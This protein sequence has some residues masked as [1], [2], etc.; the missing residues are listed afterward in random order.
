VGG[1]WLSV[2]V[3]FVGG[4]GGFLFGCGR[5]GV[6]GCWVWFLVLLF[7]WFVGVGVF[8]FGVVGFRG[9][10]GGGAPQR[11]V[12]NLK[13]SP[14]TRATTPL[15]RS[16]YRPKYHDTRVGGVFC[17]GG[18]VVGENVLGVGGLGGVL[19]G[20][21][22]FGLFVWFCGLFFVV[23]GGGWWGLLGLVLVC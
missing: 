4:W 18:C 12:E 22:V 3:F 23:V 21:V 5:G 7:G 8:F 19:G 20:G 2:V 6:V 9:G 1:W 14:P 15:T 16:I 13:H 11:R 17:V 10:V